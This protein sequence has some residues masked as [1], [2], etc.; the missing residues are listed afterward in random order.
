MPGAPV[1]PVAAPPTT[2]ELGDVGHQVRAQRHLPARRERQV[3]RGLDGPV[4]ALRGPT[5]DAALGGGAGDGALPRVADGV[6]R[7][8]VVDPARRAAGLERAARGAAHL[9]AALDG[10]AARKNQVVAERAL[11]V[12]G[13][14]PGEHEAAGLRSQGLAGVAIHA[15]AL[16]REHVGAEGEELLRGERGPGAGVAAPGGPRV[17]GDHGAAVLLHRAVE[18]RRVEGGEAVARRLGHVEVG[19]DGEVGVVGGLVALLPRED[20]DDE[21]LRARRVDQAEPDGS[22]KVSL[23]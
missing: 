17:L 12:A 1:A 9:A 8:K 19:G 16:H 20:V 3:L 7:L 2:F 13:V 15:Q 23:S 22:P 14:Q 18:E 5:P 21:I 4:A 11:A 10:G 6:A